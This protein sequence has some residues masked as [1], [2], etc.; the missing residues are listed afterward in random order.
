[1][2]H[3]DVQLDWRPVFNLYFQAK[4][5]KLENVDGEKIQ[6][7]VYKLKRFYPVE[8]AKEIWEEVS[9]LLSIAPETYISSSKCT[10][11]RGATIR[12]FSTC[13]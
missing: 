5:G 8:Q 1:M 3:K 9:R 12:G 4:Y 11:L 7:A 10:C 6:N 13:V 2:T